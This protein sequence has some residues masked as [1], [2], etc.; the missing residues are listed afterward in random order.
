LGYND[1]RVKI[2]IDDIVV[3]EG[4]IGPKL[5]K[6]TDEIDGEWVE[7]LMKWQKDRKVLHKKY[8]CMIIKK[9][10][11]LFEKGQSLI[12]IT[13]GDDEEITVCGDIHG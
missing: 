3:E 13:R 9:A 5:A 6:S 10:S 11:E 2:N 12:E 4:Y 8:A 7:G 1:S